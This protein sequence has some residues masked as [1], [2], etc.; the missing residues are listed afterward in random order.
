MDILLI[1]YT[2]TLYP[3]AKYTFSSKLVLL[4]RCVLLSSY[5]RYLAFLRA[6]C[7]GGL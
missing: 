5:T 7:L 1:L 2:Y 3:F 4:L 6:F